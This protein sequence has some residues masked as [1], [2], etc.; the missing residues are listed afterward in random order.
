MR[1]VQAPGTHIDDR[2]RRDDLCG[3]KRGG[4]AAH[5]QVAVDSELAAPRLRVHVVLSDR[6]RALSS[7]TVD[8]D[9]I[10]RQLLDLG[11]VDVALRRR[12]E[13]VGRGNVQLV[14]DLRHD[15]HRRDRRVARDVRLSR[16]DQHL[17]IHAFQIRHAGHTDSELASA[18]GQLDLYPSRECHRPANRDSLGEEGRRAA[19]ETVQALHLQVVDRARQDPAQPDLCV[20]RL[21]LTH[22]LIDHDLVPVGVFKRP[23]QIVVRTVRL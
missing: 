6:D 18:F 2:V 8:H 4:I 23:P 9:V 13:R 14:D 7:R 3:L 1:I 12:A 10:A 15:V 16:V 19:L 21:Q 5:D 22:V 17:R 20:P 11:V